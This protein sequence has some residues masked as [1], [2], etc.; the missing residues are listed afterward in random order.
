MSITLCLTALHIAQS[1]AG[2]L[3]CSGNQPLRCLLSSLCMTVIAKFLH[4]CFAHRPMLLEGVLGVPS[5]SG[6]PSPPAVIAILLTNMSA[7]KAIKYLFRC[8]W[9]LSEQLLTQTHH[10]AINQQHCCPC[11]RVFTGDECWPGQK[12]MLLPSDCT[13][14]MI[15]ILIVKV[16]YKCWSK[17][18][19]ICS[20]HQNRRLVRSLS[21]RLIS[22]QHLSAPCRMCPRSAG[23]CIAAPSGCQHRFKAQRCQ[24]AVFKACY[25]S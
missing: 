23:T 16:T 21:T 12:A 4:E 20:R 14:S 22:R 5:T 15:G 17:S 19:F 10:V 9:F 6:L 3:P 7:P 8:V 1:G 18:A 24:Y 2:L 11:M 25:V 13:I